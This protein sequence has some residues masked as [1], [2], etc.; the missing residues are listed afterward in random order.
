M[1]ER[2]KEFQDDE[3]D[4][5]EDEFQDDKDYSIEQVADS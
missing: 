1:K 5:E 3:S 2:E 4:F